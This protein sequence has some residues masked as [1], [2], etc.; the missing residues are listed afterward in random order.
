MLALSL[1]L[2][3]QGP[4]DRDTTY[5]MI[6]PPPLVSAPGTSQYTNMLLEAVLPGTN[7]LELRTADGHRVVQQL[8]KE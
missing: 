5:Q 7:L 4:A 3:A 2:F 6:V 8:V 1:N